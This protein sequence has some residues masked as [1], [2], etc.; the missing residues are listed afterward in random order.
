MHKCV[1]SDV[2]C[3]HVHGAGACVRA[4]EGLSVLPYSLIVL[5]SIIAPIF[6]SNTFLIPK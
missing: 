2:Y 6:Y 5:A 3:V 1:A 4:Y